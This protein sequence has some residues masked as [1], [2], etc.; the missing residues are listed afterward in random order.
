MSKKREPAI[1]KRGSIEDWEKSN[2]VPAEN[3]IVIKDKPDGTIELC[4]GDGETNVNYLPDI[5][6][7]R[8]KENPSVD[9]ESS[10]LIF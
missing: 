10:T 5:L 7:S 4:V 9:N 6:L 1:I 8:G 3:V 2:Y